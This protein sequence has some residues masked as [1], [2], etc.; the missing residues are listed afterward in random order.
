MSGPLRSPPREWRMRCAL[1]SYR[2]LLIAMLLV[3]CS[4]SAQGQN[5]LNTA[6]YSVVRAVFTI[7]LVSTSESEGFA[8]QSTQYCLCRLSK[9]AGNFKDA[10]PP[11]VPEEDQSTNMMYTPALTVNQDLADVCV[12]G[13]SRE[14]SDGAANVR[15]YVSRNIS[16]TTILAPGLIS[17]PGTCADVLGLLGAPDD[18]RFHCNSEDDSDAA[19]PANPAQTPV[20]EL[21]PAYGGLSPMTQSCGSTNSTFVLSNLGPAPVMIQS[22]VLSLSLWEALAPSALLASVC[23]GANGCT[24]NYSSCLLRVRDP[25][26][27]FPNA[28]LSPR[29]DGGLLFPV[30][31]SICGVDVSDLVSTKSAK[32]LREGYTAIFSATEHAD[33]VA[34]PEELIRS[35]AAWVTQTRGVTEVSLADG[36]GCQ[37]HTNPKMAT[38]YRSGRYMECRIPNEAVGHL[39][40]L[41]LAVDAAHVVHAR[42]EN[43][44]S[45]DGIDHMPCRFT[46]DLNKLVSKLSQG[47][48]LL[49]LW[50]TGSYTEAAGTSV[51]QYYR[52]PLIVIGMTHLDT[53]VVGVTRAASLSTSQDVPL[54]W[55]GLP[56]LYLFA[57]NTPLAVEQ[58]S[59]R[60]TAVCV[61]PQSCTVQELYYRS[62]NRCLQIGCIDV[63]LFSFDLETMKCRVNSTFTLLFSFLFALTVGGEVVL[64]VRRR[65][66]EEARVAHMQL[67]E[68]VQRLNQ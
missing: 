60:T 61:Q 67:V 66:T 25:R 65:R 64:I 28:T 2:Y 46:L 37:W 63:I 16:W 54:S 50:A 36:G 12:D 32:L 15:A 59:G 21:P 57:S 1:G 33:S 11:S 42:S 13:C 8:L 30:R 31:V 41:Q 34:M 55:M 35:V 14:S 58:M 48:A 6:T 62:R 9:S 7:E 56:L 22:D 24:V 40:P 4:L 52:E 43:S 68:Q 10:T 23:N 29:G 38:F 19:L 39:P 20:I 49:T 26:F 47:S 18:D 51:K 3:L 27:A 44:K 17:S 45:S 53:S 5:E